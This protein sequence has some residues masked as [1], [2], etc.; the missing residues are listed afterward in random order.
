MNIYDN[1]L[2]GYFDFIKKVENFQESD[3]LKIC[4]FMSLLELNDFDKYEAEIDKLSENAEK[5]F[6]FLNLKLFT[7]NYI[8]SYYLKFAQ[9]K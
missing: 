9:N 3:L 7:F 5:N 1:F 2:L 4:Y 6:L 8:P